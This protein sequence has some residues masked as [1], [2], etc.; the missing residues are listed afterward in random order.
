MFTNK[1]E[2]PLSLELPVCNYCGKSDALILYGAR[3]HL[4][5]MDPREFRV[6]RCSCDLVYLSPRP[7]RADLAR[8]YP[9]EYFWNAFDVV[10]AAGV[11]DAAWNAW[12]TQLV[13]RRVG[14]LRRALG[15]AAGPVL[16]VGCGRGL[17]L[18]ELARATGREVHGVDLQEDN[19]RYLAEAHPEVHVHH[20][21]FLDWEGPEGGFAG[22]TMWHLLEHLSD[23]REALR[24]AG[25]LLAPGGMLVLG[26]QNFEALSRRLMK[27]RWTLND[28]PRHLYH[29]TERTVRRHL[30]A[31]GFEVAWVTHLTEFFPTLGAHL[32]AERILDERRRVRPLRGLLA[33]LLLSPVEAVAVLMG[34]GCVM[35]LA[36]RKG[37]EVAHAR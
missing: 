30:E 12:A 7:V 3:D 31:E 2:R 25:R 37:A 10:P 34:R 17:F 24:K 32:F 14:Y 1:N 21:D 4:Y 20:A 8:A 35:T 29:F 22:V 23:P 15:S 27:E 36:A 9:A 28:V 16:D 33:N 13:R 19:V 6:V 5:G 26:T 18:R 11:L